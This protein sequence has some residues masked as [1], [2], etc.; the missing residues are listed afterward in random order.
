[1]LDAQVVIF[2]DFRITLQISFILDERDSSFLK[3]ETGGAE[4]TKSYLEGGEGTKI[5]ETYVGVASGIKVGTEID[6]GD[7]GHIRTE[8]EQHQPGK[9]VPRRSF[10][11]AP[12]RRQCHQGNQ[13]HLRSIASPPASMNG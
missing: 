7:P 12:E 1:M 8:D 5:N 11:G 9:T 4:I 13:P 2:F 6:P 3:A 10:D